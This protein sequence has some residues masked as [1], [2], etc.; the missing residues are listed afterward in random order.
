MALLLPPRI[1]H[2]VHCPRGTRMHAVVM[3]ATALTR[4]P[5]PACRV[6]T[7]NALM[8]ALM[9]AMSD[10]PH[11]YETPSPPPRIVEVLHGNLAFAPPQHSGS[12]RPPHTP[13]HSRN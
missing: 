8:G 1:K 10:L 5:E 6:I 11:A 3:A 9:D 2:A 7:V 12:D 13:M 4:S